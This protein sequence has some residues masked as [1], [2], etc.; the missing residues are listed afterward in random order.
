MA[1]RRLKDLPK[2]LDSQISEGFNNVIKITHFELS[3][4]ESTV[5]DPMPIWT[6]FFASSWKAQ[7]SP[8]TANHKAENYQPWKAIKYE[9]SINFFEKRKAGPPFTRQEPPA[10]PF[11]QMRFPVGEGKRIFNYRKSV[12]IG[13][14]AVYSQYVLETG[15]IQNFIV[16]D[17]AKIIKENM[18][19]KGKLFIGGKVSEKFSG[20]TYT[21]F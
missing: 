10:N 19:E 8:V 12:Y 5:P 13:N 17:L 20:T 3:N 11:V 7:T 15:K 14:K 2:D 18:T 4:R 6:G 9:R 16:D 1:V 21:G